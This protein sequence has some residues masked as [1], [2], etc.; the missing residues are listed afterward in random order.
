[1]F[2]LM[3][4][5]VDYDGEGSEVLILDMNGRDNELDGVA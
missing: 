1:M 5:L 4:V 2:D 3:G